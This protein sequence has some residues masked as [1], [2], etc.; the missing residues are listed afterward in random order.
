MPKELP[1][2]S[3]APTQS[4][5]ALSVPEA[6]QR[7]S[8]QNVFPSVALIPLGCSKAQVDAEEM[9]GALLVNGY[10]LEPE[11]ERADVVVVNTCGFI[12]PAKEESIETILDAA[13]LKSTANVKSVVVTGCLAERYPDQLR[14]DLPEADLIIPWSEERELVARLDELFGIKR[15]SA[16]EWGHRTLIS[17][18]HWAYLKISEGCDHT[19]SFCSI[20]GIRG[21]HV[22]V[23]MEQ[24]VDQVES[25]VELGVKEFNLVAQ[26]TT[27]WGADIYQKLSLPK[28]L[29]RLSDINGVQ[30]LRLFYAHP[31]HVTDELIDVMADCEPVIP[32]L[33]LP[34][35]HASDHLLKTMRR[36]VDRKRIEDVVGQLRHK[37]PD[38][39]LRTSVIVGIPGETEKRFHELVDFLPDIRFDRLG[40]FVYS[41][42]EGTRAAEMGGQV[43]VRLREERRDIVMYVQREISREKNESRIGTEV[44]VL[45]DRSADNGGVGRTVAE[46]PEVDGEIEV[47]S[48]ETLAPGSMVRA[49]IISA[50]DY[51]L[52]ATV[53]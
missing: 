41:N 7:V 24:L 51:D 1:T 11:P 34:I 2:V 8:E 25:L 27:L 42:E 30:W 49:R 36:I 29:R 14:N 9:I 17:P 13:E 33:D 46:A 38:I 39:T 12:E 37:V 10:R 20:P 35:Q 23:P 47:S 53:V 52:C 15:T 28:L 3:S 22:S 5:S 43:P 50:Q 44:D 19:C 40:C 48:D 16:A 6:M 21:K 45:I 18:R 32:Y 31:A 26:D 4:R